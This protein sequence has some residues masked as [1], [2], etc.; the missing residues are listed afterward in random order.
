MTLPNL[1]IVVIGAGAAGAVVASRLSENSQ[2]SVLLLEAGPD[3]ESFQEPDGIKSS[4]FL[5]ALQVAER[6]FEDLYVQR[7]ALQGS[8]WYPRG[9]GMGGSTSVNA[10]VAMAGMAE[11]FE[12]WKHH[13]GC[14]GWGW[15]D[16]GPVF[17]SL[18]FV[19]TTVDESDWGV[20]DSALVEALTAMGVS[21]ND[22]L[23]SDSQ[24][25]EAVGAATL[26]FDG[27]QRCSTN[28]VYMDGARSRPNLIIRAN[29]EVDSIVMNGTR[30]VG[31]K[32]SDGSVIDASGV[33][34][35]AGAIH[36]PAVLLRSNIHR[37]GIG[38]GLKDHPAVALSL[39]LREEAHQRFAISAIS[40]LSSSIGSSDIHLLPMNAVSN[41]DNKSGA[42]LAAV[43]EVTSIGSVQIDS[44][45]RPE[46]DFCLLS[47]EHDVQVMRDAVA[48]SLQVLQQK[49]FTDV[50]S[51][52]YCDNLGTPC[53]WLDAAPTEQF[54]Q[55]M[56]RNVGVY[57]HAGCS[58]RMG[59][60]D[61]DDAVVDTDG[62][63]IGHQAVWV[64]DASI[65]PDLPRANPQLA[66]TMLAER[67]SPRIAGWLG[68]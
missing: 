37:R 7:T 5:Q 66:V 32:L 22:H 45:R 50:V 15:S 20:I 28:A 30:A 17:A 18:P 59:S 41:N 9:R 64:C 52:T 13:H 14:N 1:P 16:V 68:L 2:Q 19:T 29:C 8:V 57:A 49:A 40:R 38:K 46:V 48:R 61:D 36:S 23:S 67:I 47:T 21:R 55:W 62:A 51:A 60:T 27:K 63:L 24:T 58:L 65:F 34:L 4:N 6:T 11:D 42:L 54:D 56:L 3:T 33:V 44:N 39:Q 12:R 31:V 10:M 43:M 25:A 53:D 35:C 26:L